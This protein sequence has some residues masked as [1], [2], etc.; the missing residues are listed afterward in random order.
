MTKTTSLALL[1][2]LPALLLGCTKPEGK[3]NTQNGAGQTQSSA[4][5]LDTPPPKSAALAVRV[6]RPSVGQLL[7][8][9]S[10]SA[11]IK[12]S[13]DSNVAATTSGAVTS[14]PVQEGQQVAQGAVVVQLDTSSQRQALTNARLQLQQAQINLA[15]TQR[16]TGQNTGQL[17]SAI[18]SAQASYDKALAQ[19]NANRQLYKVGA[20][21][22]TDYQ[23]SEAA[24]AQAQSSLA[25]A[26][27]SLA[28]NG[29]SGSGSIDLLRNQVQ[30]AQASVQQAQ[31]NLEKA[32]VRAPFGGTVASI[33][34]KVGEYVNTGS[35]VFRL[36]DPGSLS[37]DFKV[38]PTDALTLKAGTQLQ[39][40]YGSQSFNATIKEGD[41][42][43]GADRLVPLSARLSSAA[44]PLPVGSV[45]QVRYKAALG[46]GAIVPADAVV[47]DGG[48]NAVYV[49][50]NGAAKR[51]PVQIS[52]ESQGKVVLS[53][54]SAEQQVIYPVPPSLQDGSTVRVDSAASGKAG[55]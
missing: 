54:I 38:P 46:R 30:S 10:A 9:R 51:V 44:S 45:G 18:Q 37:A 34:A 55:Q 42:V 6:I 25:Q 27:N 4:S 47:N 3:T 32:S 33:S 29:Q 2:L 5:G 15:Q 8:S 36:V 13:H 28:Q 43:A 49:V 24:L 35:A 39:F 53:G 23:A 31:E 21:S 48:Q 26:K 1:T 52:A 12:A 14:V 7:V 40:N 11:T 20:I 16:N 50:S 22:A 19:A 41:R 17:G